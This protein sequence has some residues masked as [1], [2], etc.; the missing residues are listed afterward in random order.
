MELRHPDAAG[1]KQNAIVVIHVSL[2]RDSYL[3]KVVHVF[4]YLRAFENTGVNR[5]GDGEENGDDY[6][7][8]EQF[9]KRESAR[10]ILGHSTVR[11]KRHNIRLDG[12]VEANSGWKIA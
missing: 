8:D 2:R 6:H 3:A 5:V 4:C 1:S 10:E 12:E 9:D 7:D 11:L